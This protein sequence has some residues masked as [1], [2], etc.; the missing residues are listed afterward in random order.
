MPEKH[1]LLPYTFVP[2]V[3]QSCVLLMVNVLKTVK[4]RRL[5]HLKHQHFTIVLLHLFCSST[6]TTL[7]EGRLC[8]GSKIFLSPANFKTFSAN[9]QNVSTSFAWNPLWSILWKTCCQCVLY[10]GSHNNKTTRSRLV[11]HSFGVRVFCVDFENFHCTHNTP[12][13]LPAAMHPEWP[14]LVFIHAMTTRHQ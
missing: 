1:C 14:L 2:Q 8:G 13:L 12:P 5:L 3:L 10:R 6:K 4:Q 11:T 7:V 9:S